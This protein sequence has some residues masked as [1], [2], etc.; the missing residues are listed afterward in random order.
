MR[1]GYSPKQVQSAKGGAGF[2]L[3]A[4][5]LALAATALAQT[6]LVREVRAAIAQGDFKLGESL[7]DQSRSTHGPTPDSILALSWLG[8]GAQAAR[9]WDAADRYAA[10]T[11]DLALQ[12]LKSR[13]LDQEPN[14][15]LAL[16]ASIEVQAHVLDARGRRSEAIQ[17]LQRELAAY[18]DTSI[19]TR[20][21]KNINLLSLEGKPAPPLNVEEYVGPKPPTL[22][23][24]KGKVVLLFLWAHW[25]G[26][27]KAQALVLGRVYEKY[28]EQGL[29]LV[30]PTQRYG[31]TRRGMDAT[32]AE[33]KPYIDQ[34]RKEHYAMLS[35]MPVPI[36]EETFRNYGASTTPT[37][38]LVDR[39]GIV[40]LYHP[41]QMSDA[42]LE[43]R[44]RTLL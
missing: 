33:E 26:D 23:S 25:C 6:H 39:A 2:S 21:Q 29:V 19:R 12:Q 14:L 5:F 8:R 18:K 41:G 34:V 36:H 13:P 28:R 15:P 35:K 42:E 7:V 4:L 17:F 32:P 44:I 16:G 9:N 40:R 24:L 38:V 11:R 37:L 1:P 22:E 27:C 3:A 10:Q 20:I 30:G 43:A 31:Y